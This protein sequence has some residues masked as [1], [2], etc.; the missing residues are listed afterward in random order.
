MWQTEQNYSLEKGP[1]CGST[2][3][4]V[5]LNNLSRLLREHRKGEAQVY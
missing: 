4:S 5:I 2:T 3:S 1:F